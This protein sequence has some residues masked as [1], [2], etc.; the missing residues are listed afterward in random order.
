MDFFHLTPTQWILAG[1]AAIS[2]GISK[3]G[4]GGVGILTVALMAALMSGHER[5]STGVVLP[6]LITG[7]LLATRAFRGHVRW[8]V[9]IRLLPPAMI[10]VCIGFFWMRGL[11][12]TGFK[13]M[14]GWIVLALAALQFFRQI[15]PGIFQT[16]PHR[17]DFAWAVGITAGITTMLAN[18]AG[19]IMALY[20][21]AVQL[22]KLE[23]VATAA[24]YF[25]IV[26]LFKVP[27]SANL[28]FIRP[29]SLLFNAALIPL[30]ALGI[31]S[32]RF[33]LHRLDQ[34]LFEQLLLGLIGLT[35]LHLI[36]F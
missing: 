24:W 22:P 23:F 25:L 7:D 28:G 6:L 17:R 31:A 27:F 32:G 33:F 8:P 15:Q 3:S 21:L 34:K 36:F 5:E 13:P 26:N 12:N 10:G 30:V 4:F 16:I 1:F 18:A 14:I 2:V 20:F 9:L 35:A 19:P 11:S 29:E